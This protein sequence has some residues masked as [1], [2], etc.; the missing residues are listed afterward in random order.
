MSIMIDL[1]PTMVQE[2]R[3]YACDILDAAVQSRP[4]A[5]AFER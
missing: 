1:P 5:G 2:A 4:I 3:D